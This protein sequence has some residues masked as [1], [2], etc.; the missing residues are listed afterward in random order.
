MRC[1]IAVAHSTTS[2]PRAT[3]PSASAVT[4][5]CS[6]VRIAAS[7]PLRALSSSRKANSTACRLASEAPAQAGKAAFAEATAAATSDGR[8]EPDLARDG[9]FGG[10]VDGRG[11]GG[12]AGE[13]RAVDPVLEDLHPTTLSLGPPSPECR[14]PMAHWRHGTGLA[15]VRTR[16]RRPRRRPRRAAAA[17]PPLRRRPCDDRGATR[18]RARGVAD[19]GAGRAVAAHRRA[20]R[21]PGHRGRAARATRRTR[22]AAARTGRAGARRIEGAAGALARAGDAAH[23]AAEGQR[24]RAAAQPAVRRDRRAAQA[25]AG[26]GGADPRDHRVARVGAAQQLDSRRVGRDAV[27]QRRAGRRALSSGSTSTCSRR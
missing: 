14:R 10:I 6:F 4:L 25:D 1:G 11:A 18:E 24:P 26:L 17:F 15:H 9:A 19:A 5:P 13:E 27:A 12:F 16:G 22:A 20:R 7:S 21:H 8:R 23:D 3:S 2:M